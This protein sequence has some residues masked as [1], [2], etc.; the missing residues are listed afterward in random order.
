MGSVY[1]DPE[2]ERAVALGRLGMSAEGKIRDAF[3]LCRGKGVVGPG[4]FFDEALRY[5]SWDEI[6]EFFYGENGVVKETGSGVFDMFAF[7]E[8]M[9]ANGMRRR[10][11][12]R[13]RFSTLVVS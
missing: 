10:N 12:V 2:H 13:E 6:D 1:E 9:M 5:L 3:F 8:R 7:K 4:K 11:D